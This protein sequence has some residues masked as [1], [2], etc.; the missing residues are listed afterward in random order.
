MSVAA[1]VVVVVV[2]VIVQWQRRR[3]SFFFGLFVYCNTRVGVV[4]SSYCLRLRCAVCVWG[5]MYVCVCGRVQNCVNFVLYIPPLISTA[6]SSET[7]ALLWL[8]CS[9]VICLSLSPTPSPSSFVCAN[10]MQ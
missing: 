10:Y 2:V 5:G 9:A 6:W 1:D 7:I 4:L 3:Q 8:S